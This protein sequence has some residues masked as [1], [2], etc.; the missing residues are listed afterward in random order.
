M[1]VSPQVW[2]LRRCHRPILVLK[3]TLHNRLK[4]EVYQLCLFFG[5]FRR[6]RIR[7]FR[8]GLSLALTVMV[9]ALVAQ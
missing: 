2:Q 3:L 5:T 1:R 4:L 6:V 7:R 8:I 9:A